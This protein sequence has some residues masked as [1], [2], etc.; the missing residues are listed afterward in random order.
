M[1]ANGLL[2]SQNWANILHKLRM[3]AAH[4]HITGIKKKFRVTSPAFCDKLLII[5]FF[6][7]NNQKKACVLG[8]V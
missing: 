3:K 7:L 8:Y 4:H 6:T 2:K 5:S 1:T